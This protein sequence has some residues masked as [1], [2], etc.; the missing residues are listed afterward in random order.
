MRGEWS[1]WDFL[2]SDKK[3]DNDFI[4]IVEANFNYTTPN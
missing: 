1:F 3:L 2:M 4:Y